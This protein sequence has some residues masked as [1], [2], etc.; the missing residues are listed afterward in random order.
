[1][2]CSQVWR[3][4][5]RMC[6]LH[7]IHPKQTAEDTL[8]SVMELRVKDSAVYTPP[9]ITVSGLEPV[10]FGSQVQLSNR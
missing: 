10:T 7:L 4:I 5:L 2:T 1:M 3:P 6:G 8:I 9:T